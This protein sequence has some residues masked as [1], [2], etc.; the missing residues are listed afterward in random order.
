MYF[1]LYFERS[2]NFLGF[3]I[4]LISYMIERST[5]RFFYSICDLYSEFKGI[6]KMIEKITIQCME[7]LCVNILSGGRRYIRTKSS[8]FLYLSYI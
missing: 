1:M 2:G 7:K 3:G 5:K 6:I 8:K 4:N